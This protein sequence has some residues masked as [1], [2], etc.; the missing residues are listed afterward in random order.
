MTR[1][2]P[3]AVLVTASLAVALALTAG[4]AIASPI[5]AVGDISPP[6]TE[7]AS[8]N[9][10][11]VAALIRQHNPSDLLLVGDI[12]YQVGRYEE[13]VD[14]F[15]YIEPGGFGADDL[16]AKSIPINGNHEAMD[17]SRPYLA[18]MRQ[19]FGER[20]R[21]GVSQ[22][23]WSFDRDG[24]HY[25]VL[26]SNCGA[27][28]NSPSC[29]AGSAQANWLKADLA[30]SNARCVIGL[31]HIPYRSSTAPFNGSFDN[32]HTSASLWTQMVLGGVSAV[33]NGHN[34]AEEILRPMRT[35]G[36]VDSDSGPG[37]RD[38]GLGGIRTFIAGGGGRS[39]VPFTAIHPQSTYRA[40]RYGFLKIV[41]NATRTGFLAGFKY[42]DGTT[43]TTTAY[44]C[45][46]RHGL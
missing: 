25:V 5:I 1:R 37:D 40:N 12:Q 33:I 35:K 46:H 21:P 7:A 19:F 26:D 18:G 14:Q 20:G 8:V 2:L 45:N 10:H 24:I 15:G 9:D 34:H 30:A 38:D 27:L 41:P 42:T 39:Q 17:T 23:Y 29:A 32:A 3:P 16:V 4:T 28:V 6:P 11:A 43:S 22:S 44:G 31:F 36:N 13:Y